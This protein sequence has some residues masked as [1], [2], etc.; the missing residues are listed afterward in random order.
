MITPC[1]NEDKHD[2]H[3]PT[4]TTWCPG[5]LG[6][7]PKPRWVVTAHSGGGSMSEAM[8]PAVAVMCDTEQA[9][10]TLNEGMQQILTAKDPY[11][12]WLV[13]T[14]PLEPFSALPTIPVVNGTV[15][16]PYTGKTSNVSPG[17]IA[18]DLFEFIK[19]FHEDIQ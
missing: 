7:P 16:D 19:S 6:K 3:N 13:V 4:P 15:T 14:T 10:N 17:Q 1:D 9:A 5:A 2:E 11:G 12:D 18:I 8:Q